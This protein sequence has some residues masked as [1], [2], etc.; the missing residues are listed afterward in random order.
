MNLIIKNKIKNMIQ[1]K[2][3]ENPIEILNQNNNLSFKIEKE[4]DIRIINN[5]INLLEI[6]LEFFIF[7][8]K[9]IYKSFS[10]SITLPIK[11]LE[12]IEKVYK[13]DN[14]EV[15]EMIFYHQNNYQIEIKDKNISISE[16]YNNKNIYYEVHYIGG[17]E[18]LTFIKTFPVIIL[19]IEEAYKKYNY[20][21]LNILKDFESIILYIKSYAL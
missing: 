9:I 15:N 20:D 18:F 4:E 1:I 5:I 3:V 8:K 12:L 11:P 17:Y 10:I 14:N 16:N 2:N 6:N 7:R 13:I 21:K 19:L